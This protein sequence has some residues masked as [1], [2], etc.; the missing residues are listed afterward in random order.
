VIKLGSRTLID[1]EHGLAYL[2]TIPGPLLVV[3]V[4]IMSVPSALPIMNRLDY[5]KVTNS[6]QRSPS[7]HYSDFNYFCVKK[8]RKLSYLDFL[9]KL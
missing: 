7:Y 1:V 3:R 4:P 5:P 2:A 6:R 8:S 9:P